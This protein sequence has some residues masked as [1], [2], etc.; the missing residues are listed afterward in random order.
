MVIFSLT[1]VVSAVLRS[2]DSVRSAP[3]MSVLA[4]RDEPSSVLDTVTVAPERDTTNSWF[5]VAAV[6]VIPVLTRATRALYAAV[7]T[8]S[9]LSSSLMA[10][11]MPTSAATPGFAESSGAGADAGSPSTLN[12]RKCVAVAAM[13]SSCSTMYL[14]RSSAMLS[15]SFKKVNCVSSRKPPPWFVVC[16]EKYLA[17][18]AAGTSVV[19]APAGL[20]ADSETESSVRIRLLPSADSAV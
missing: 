1:P 2:E 9:A 19:V 13:E 11:S 8:A 16:T 3:S 15:P 20:F 6:D 5:R 7:A 17:T 4:S 18:L 12:H 14:P 10:T